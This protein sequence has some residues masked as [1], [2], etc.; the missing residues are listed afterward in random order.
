MPGDAFNG[1]FA[2]AGGTAILTVMI[3]DRGVVVVTI[4]QHRNQATVNQPRPTDIARVGC[5]PADNRFAIVAPV[6][7][8]LQAFWVKRPTAEAL[9]V[10]RG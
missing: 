1:L 3:G 6:A 9:T 4:N 2:V 8:N 5:K 7:F 10:W